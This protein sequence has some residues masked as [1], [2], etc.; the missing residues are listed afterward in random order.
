[1]VGCT[2][3]YLSPVNCT[4][5]SNC[6]GP[7]PELGVCGCLTNADCSEV[8]N[9]LCNTETKSCYL[10]IPTET[11]PV[12][13][14]CVSYKTDFF[15]VTPFACCNSSA[16][17]QICPPYGVNVSMGDLV[18]ENF[19]ELS[20]EGSDVVQTTYFAMMT[21][22]MNQLY[23]TINANDL[24]QQMN[25]TMCKFPPRIFNSSD[26]SLEAHADRQ[27]MSPNSM[28]NNGTGPGEGYGGGNISSYPNCVPQYNV[29]MISN[30]ANDSSI[31][32]LYQPANTSALP[33]VQLG[34][35]II[36]KQQVFLSSISFLNMNT[37]GMNFVPL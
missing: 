4:G 31:D 26:A 10:S 16:C 34:L 3:D 22:D 13:S 20:S 33:T 36:F 15:A 25:V 12:N 7:T 9:Y 6:T 8:S 19:D 11:T 30:T 28:C 29:I 32:E 1:M 2:L 21:V 5:V 23:V 18:V 24:Q 37:L 14:A 27:L 17:L 35:Q